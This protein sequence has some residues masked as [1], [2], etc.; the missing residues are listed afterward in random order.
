MLALFHVA[1]RLQPELPAQI[2][3][4]DVTDSEFQDKMYYPSVSYSHYLMHFFIW[5]GMTT[6]FGYNWNKIIANRRLKL[7]KLSYP[8]CSVIM[9]IRSYSSYNYEMQKVLMFDS[10]VEQRAKELF[11]Q[12]KFLFDTESFK[13]YVYFQEDLKETMERVHR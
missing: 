10:Y 9:I 1:P 3:T 4:L 11:E 12:N 5:C 8:I 7:L 13:K 2:F 6:F